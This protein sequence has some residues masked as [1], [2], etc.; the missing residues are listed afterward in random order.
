MSKHCEMPCKNLDLD[1]F[2]IFGL[3][4]N[5][6]KFSGVLLFASK[7]KI[8]QITRVDDLVRNIKHIFRGNIGLKFDF[9]HFFLF[10]VLQNFIHTM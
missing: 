8:I 6:L 9:H 5:K 1:Y 2:I 7:R 4:R 3:A 10:Q